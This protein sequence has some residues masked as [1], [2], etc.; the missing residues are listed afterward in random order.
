MIEAIKNFVGYGLLIIAV[1]VAV[2]EAAKSFVAC[3]KIW[4]MK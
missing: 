4:R 2:A 1:L 3:W